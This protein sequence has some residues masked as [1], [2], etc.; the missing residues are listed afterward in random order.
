[1]AGH[2]NPENC[3]LSDI[4]AD[5]IEY[6]KLNLRGLVKSQRI[7]VGPGLTRWSGQKFDLIVSDVSG[8]S[9]EIARA[10]DWYDGIP[11]GCGTD[12]LTNTL[13][14]LRSAG[15]FLRE[16][17][18]LVFPV[19]SLSDVTRLRSAIEAEFHQV[20][21][22]EETKWPL[23]QDLA[24]N[25]ALIERLSLDRRIFI[26]RKYGRILATTSIAVCSEPSKR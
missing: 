25:L 15:A 7:V 14:V 2:L 23:P 18:S 19:I 13:E 5:A 6:A 3:W 9:E 4:S 20:E 21:F 11:S 8:I 22:Q 1:M 12:G 26:E 16:S 10:S 24:S 17:G